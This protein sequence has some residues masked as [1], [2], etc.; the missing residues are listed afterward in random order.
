MCCDP[1]STSKPLHFKY[2][3]KIYRCQ[4]GTFCSQLCTFQ[5][6][7]HFSVHVTSV[8]WIHC[9]NVL[10]TLCYTPEEPRK[11][12]SQKLSGVPPLWAAGSKCSQVWET[13]QLLWTQQYSWWGSGEK[14]YH[15]LRRE[16]NVLSARSSSQLPCWPQLPAPLRSSCPTNF[17]SVEHHFKTNFCA[18]FSLLLLAVL[19]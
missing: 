1:K 11:W 18:L 17:A 12:M 2:V 9:T 4:I 16:V 19:F 6:L 14:R 7:N 3:F 8:T 10:A 13:G 15:R 5:L